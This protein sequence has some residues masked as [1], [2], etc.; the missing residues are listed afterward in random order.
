MA[1]CG[2]HLAKLGRN[3][4]GHFAL[5]K[6]HDV[7]LFLVRSEESNGQGRECLVGRAWCSKNAGD[8]EESRVGDTGNSEVFGAVDG[9]EVVAFVY[10]R[11]H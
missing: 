6:Y 11:R 7:S 9:S 3:R 10:H 8:S 2:K 1:D 5:L 4:K